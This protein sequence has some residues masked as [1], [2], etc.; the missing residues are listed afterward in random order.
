MPL[1]TKDISLISVAT[2]AAFAGIELRKFV[3][4]KIK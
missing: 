4:R 1:G 2:L 3:I